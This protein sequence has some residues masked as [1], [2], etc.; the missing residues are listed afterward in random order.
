[1]LL[2]DDNRSLSDDKNQ[3]SR[4]HEQQLT[5]NRKR[6][7]EVREQK[8]ALEARIVSLEAQLFKAQVDLTTRA[9]EE[10]V[11]IPISSS[12][13]PDTMCGVFWVK[14]CGIQHKGSSCT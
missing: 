14:E 1:L 10:K 6:N 11:I 8:E 7:R 2:I 13:C 3:M 9:T 5:D 4:G 12:A